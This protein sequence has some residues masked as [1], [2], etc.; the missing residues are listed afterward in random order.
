M[1]KTV[2]CLALLGTVALGACSN[3][4]RGFGE[5][6]EHTGQKIQDSANHPNE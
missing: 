1:K 2:L 5:D 3:T 4:W 6:T